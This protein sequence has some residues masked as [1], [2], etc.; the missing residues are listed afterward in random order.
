MEDFW[1][2]LWID[3][4][5]DSNTVDAIKWYKNGSQYHFYVPSFVDLTQAKI[6][7]NFGSFEI[8]STDY[9]NG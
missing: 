2:G 8:D 9:N 4:K 5:G 3:T 7:S 6:Y 1:Y